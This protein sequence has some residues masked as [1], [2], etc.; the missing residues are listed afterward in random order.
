MTAPKVTELM[1]LEAMQDVS[2]DVLHDGK[3]TICSI[4]FFDRFT[5][6]GESSCVFVEN[7]NAQLGMRYAYEDAFNQ[8]WKF[9]G[10]L[11][12]YQSFNEPKDYKA[13]MIMELQQIEGRLEGLNKALANKT[14]VDT[15][16]PRKHRHM[17]K[18]REAMQDYAYW[19][20][21]RVTEMN[22]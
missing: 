16:E 17:V 11:L 13:L 7:F 5:I 15:L 20:N 14:F 3:T 9:F 1:M 8:C 12:A 10:F 6:R 4:K 19:L 21:L 22:L 2:F 18:Q